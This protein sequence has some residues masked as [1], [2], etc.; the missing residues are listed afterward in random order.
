MPQD[1]LE[2]LPV[3]VEFAADEAFALVVNQN[4][5]AN[6]GPIL[7]VREHPSGSQHGPVKKVDRTSILAW[8][9]G[10]D[11]W[12][13][14]SV[15]D[16]RSQPRATLLDRRSHCWVTYDCATNSPT[17]AGSES[18]PVPPSRSTDRLERRDR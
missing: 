11:P 14:R 13:L 8:M 3:D 16:R 10:G 15:R 4:A 9:L 18:E 12:A 2:R 17:P 7:H 1:L 6:L 5:T